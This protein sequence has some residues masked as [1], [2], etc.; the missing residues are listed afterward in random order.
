MLEGDSAGGNLVLGVLS[1]ILHPHPLVK[2]LRLSR[3]FR[4]VA[5]VSPWGEFG[6]SRRSY[7]TKRYKDV[8]NYAVIKKRSDYFM[9]EAASDE[10][11]QPFYSQAFNNMY[12]LNQMNLISG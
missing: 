10:Y 6:E 3:P 2:P 7:Q 8:L 1:Q 11:N 4:A 12:I 9:G 5:L